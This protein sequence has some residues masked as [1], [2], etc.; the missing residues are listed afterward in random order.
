MATRD[1][2]RSDRDERDRRRASEKSDEYRF[3]DNLP[4]GAGTVAETLLEATGFRGRPLAMAPDPWQHGR[5]SHQP[6]RATL[7]RPSR[8]FPRPATPP[9]QQPVASQARCQRGIAGWVARRWVTSRA[10]PDP[11]K[12]W[13]PCLFRQRTSVSAAQ[14]Q[15]AS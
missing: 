6:G 5:G 2:N 15:A 3:A 12:V 10:R 14:A 7:Q 11:A 9:P 13:A 4:D 1:G 8:A